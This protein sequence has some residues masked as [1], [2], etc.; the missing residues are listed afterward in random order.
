MKILL[1]EPPE[2]VSID[3][4]TCS[5]I[6][7]TIGKSDEI[8]ISMDCRHKGP[9]E[10]LLIDNNLKYRRIS[11]PSLSTIYLTDVVTP[12]LY[13]S[14]VAFEFNDMNLAVILY[15]RDNKGML[16]YLRPHI[17]DLPIDVLFYPILDCDIPLLDRVN[18][19][20]EQELT[21]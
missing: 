8:Y 2:C 18:N 17:E 16:R 7:T 4:E 11:T 14:E 5:I 1:V 10:Q 13:G 19:H 20:L 15:N 6:L 21:F 12:T 3:E 9:T